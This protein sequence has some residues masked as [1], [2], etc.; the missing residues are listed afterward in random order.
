[1]K[2]II[3]IS[4]LLA[5]AMLLAACGGENTVFDKSSEA[6]SDT[7]SAESVAESDAESVPADAGG[8]LSAPWEESDEGSDPE[9]DLGD[10]D[11]V[12]A[13]ELALFFLNR[14]A[15]PVANVLV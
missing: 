1:M 9:L 11:V 13:L 14:Y 15:G 10:D 2:K 8:D 3:L 5:L 7:V 4:C 6:V 12:E